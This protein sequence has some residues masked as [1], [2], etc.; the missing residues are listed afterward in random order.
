MKKVLLSVACIVVLLCAG[1]AS[2]KVVNR[3]LPDQSQADLEQSLQQ[4]D[5]RAIAPDHRDR[6]WVRPGEKIS[7]QNLAKIDTS[8]VTPRYT[9]EEEIFRDIYFD[10][11]QYDIRADAVTVLQDISSW[12]LKNTSSNLLIEGHCD[13]RGT[14]EYN[15]A[16]GDRRAKAVRDYLAALGVRSA[17]M[18]IL[19]YGE[20]QP[21]CL[22]RS[23]SCWT[24]NRRAHFVVAR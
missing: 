22:E 23:E 14:S 4:Q 9:K 5:S 11:D 24:K 1:C 15:L 7:E 17:R 10:Y 18:E 2:R 19:S 16:L 20:E 13:D 3:D 21:I 6:S 12:M 8:T